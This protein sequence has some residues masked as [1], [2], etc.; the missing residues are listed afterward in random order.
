MSVLKDDIGA[1]IVTAMQSGNRFDAILGG[2]GADL[3]VSYQVV[4]FKD[5][6]ATQSWCLIVPADPVRLRRVGSTQVT[7][8]RFL[9]VFHIGPRNDRG[10]ARTEIAQ[11][12]AA[13]F[14]EGGDDLLDT[15]ITDTGSN[16]RP[17]GGGEVEWT[18]EPIV[19]AKDR[20]G[21]TEVLTYTIAVTVPHRYALA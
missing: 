8:F 18:D 2:D 10:L 4:P 15:H 3:Y 1:G 21:E 16:I 12:F 9:A 11:A 19:G 7:R 14:G 5:F 6:D 13:A 20:Q 17:G